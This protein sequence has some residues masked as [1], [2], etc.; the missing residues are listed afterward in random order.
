M[1]VFFTHEKYS[2]FQCVYKHITKLAFLV[3]G[4]VSAFFLPVLNGAGRVARRS[5]VAVDVAVDV[6]V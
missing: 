5:D 3:A 6:D 1:P 4:T 2:H